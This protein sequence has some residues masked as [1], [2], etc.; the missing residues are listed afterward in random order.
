MNH[1]KP[2]NWS[3]SFSLKFS[4]KKSQSQQDH[5]FYNTVFIKKPHSFYEPQLTQYCK[6][7]TTATKRKTLLTLKSLQQR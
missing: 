1:S 7:Y 2:H 4:S 3:L 5:S 6:K